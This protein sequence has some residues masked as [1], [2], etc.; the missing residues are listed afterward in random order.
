MQVAVA[1]LSAGPLTVRAQAVIGACVWGTAHVERYNTT[2]SLGAIS[3]CASIRV[4][5]LKHVWDEKAHLEWN[6]VHV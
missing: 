2:S 5:W 3:V 4:S 1:I 6:S